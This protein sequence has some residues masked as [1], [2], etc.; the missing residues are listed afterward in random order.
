M[1]LMA[2]LLPFTA[3]AQ[4]AGPSV[5]FMTGKPFFIY[6]SYDLGA[7]GYFILDNRSG[8]VVSLL[9]KAD[10]AGHAQ[11]DWIFFQFRC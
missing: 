4:M 6:G 11:P 1:I 5:T 8:T 10:G 7:L 9:K 3:K 2:G